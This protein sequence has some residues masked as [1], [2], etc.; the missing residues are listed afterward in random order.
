MRRATWIGWLCAL[1]TLGVSGCKNPPLPQP[2]MPDDR[3]SVGHDVGT[4]AFLVLGP[5]DLVRV[6]VYGHPELSTPETGTRVDFEGRL[7]LPLV[8]AVEISGLSSR[9][10]ASEIEGRLA[11]YVREPSVALS[12]VEYTSRRVYVFGDVKAPG[13]FVLD[14]PLNALQA[15]GL[16]GGFTPGADRQ[17]VCLLRTE[18]QFVEVHVFNVEVPDA[19]ALVAV[20][21]DD[22][23]FVRQTG[24]G[25]FREQVLPILQG[26]QPGLSSLINLGLVADA[27]ND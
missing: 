26:V 14:R 25:A 19:N 11:R 12:V 7:S 20:R 13:P 27:I 3:L 5:N 23:L 15:L 4:D 2:T 17:N 16:A 18:G 24:A 9:A 1:V 6:S 10:A 8:G 21:P 22:F